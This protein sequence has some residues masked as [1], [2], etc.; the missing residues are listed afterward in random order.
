MANLRKRG[1]EDRSIGY[2]DWRREVG[3][4]N[5]CQDIDQVEYR[6][7]DGEV[8]PVLMLELTRYDYENEPASQYFNA[9]LERFGKSQRRAATHFA[10]LLGVDCVIVLFKFNLTRFWL[11]NLSTDQGWY[12]LNEGGYRKWLMEHKG[13]G[14]VDKTSPLGGDIHTSPKGEIT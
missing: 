14:E 7:V 8:V 11:F 1:N 6:I 10:Q 2:T 5:L 12:S 9:I 3:H 4:G 13:R